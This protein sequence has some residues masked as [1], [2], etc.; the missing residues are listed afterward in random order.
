MPTLG[1]SEPFTNDCEVARAA[2]GTMA[3]LANVGATY[4]TQ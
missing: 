1:R 3:W 4:Q 2:S